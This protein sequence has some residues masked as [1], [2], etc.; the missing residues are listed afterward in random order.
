MIHWKSL[1]K[2]ALSTVLIAALIATVIKIFI[3]DNRIVP[4]S[5]MYPTIYVGDM[6][7]VNKTAYYFNDPQR[8]DIVVFK[9]EKEIGQKD[10]VKRVIGLPGETVV[11][12][13]N[14]V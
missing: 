14:K 10:L 11:V 12:Q 9:P 13:E 3:V 5:S 6:L 4:S 7:L 1:L 2:E 8:G